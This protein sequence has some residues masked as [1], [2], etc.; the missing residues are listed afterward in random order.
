MNVKLLSAACVLAAVSAGWAAGAG[1]GAGAPQRPELDTWSAK[2]SLG[3]RAMKQVVLSI[4]ASSAEAGK[5]TFYVPSGY[6]LDPSGPPGTREGFAFMATGSD[7]AFGDLQAVNPA[8]YVN[9][10]AAQACAP[11][12]H[13][14][15]W[16]M[17]FTESFF[18]AQSATIPIYVDRTSGDEAALGAYKL[19]ACLP[20]AA[21]ASPGGPPIGTQLR[22]LELEFTRI[23][24]P[25]SAANYVWR[26][27]VS[28]PDASGNADPATTYELRS[29]MPLPAKLSLTKRFV[30]EHQRAVLSGRLTTSAAPTGGVTV[31]LYRRRS[32]F[33]WKSVASTQTRADGSYRFARP[34]AKSGT[35][36]TEIGAVGDCVGVSSAPN[37]CLSE[38][39]GA[40]DSPNVRVVLR[41]VR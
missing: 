25:T 8:A 39:R 26:A 16:I 36:G 9:S 32:L 34:V 3:A 38:T 17:N 23:T 28:N 21:V 4:P 13:T 35:Y 20:L 5:V 24:N 27:F 10:P 11:G 1:A 29:D 14:G 37:G 2:P 19:Q 33:G 30:G 40:I 7:F 6:T 22:G 15:V 18:S 41:R 12:A 31:T